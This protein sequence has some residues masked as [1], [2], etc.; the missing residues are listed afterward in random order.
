MYNKCSCK[1]MIYEEQSLKLILETYFS[2]IFF[3][4]FFDY[5][6]YEFITMEV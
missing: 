2:L 5:R 4:N 6:V 1:L 3:I